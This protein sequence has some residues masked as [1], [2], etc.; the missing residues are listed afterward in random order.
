MPN[1][2]HVVFK[3]TVQ[4]MGQVIADWKDKRLAKPTSCWADEVG[5]GRK[6][7][8]TPICETRSMNCRRGIMRKRTR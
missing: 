7:I 5:S 1:H 8:G 4:P 2:L 6:I 3:I